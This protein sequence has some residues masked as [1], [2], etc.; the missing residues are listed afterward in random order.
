MQ[1]MYLTTP[2]TLV[3]AITLISLTV[4]DGIRYTVQRARQ[5]AEG[6]HVVDVRVTDAGSH[7]LQFPDI[8]EITRQI[9]VEE[10]GANGHHNDGSAALTG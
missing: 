7:G 5:S 2:I 3:T 6:V 10:F 1:P 8:V 4:T 9:P